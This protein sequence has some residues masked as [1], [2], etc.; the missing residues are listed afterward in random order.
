[1]RRFLS[2]IV[3]CSAVS[4]AAFAAPLTFVYKGAGCTGL[5]ALGQYE[6]LIGRKVDGVADF[7]DFS[8]WQNMLI[9]ANWGLNCWSG[10]VANISLS[11]PMAVSQNDGAPLQ[12]LAAGD[13]NSYYTQLAKMLVSYGFPNAFLR[14]GEEFNGDWY[15]WAAANSPTIWAKGFQQIVTTM[16]AV[17]GAKFKFVW[18]PALYAQKVSPDLAYP[19]DGYVDVVGT[20]AYDVS[21][22][23]GYTAPA[24]RWAS[25]YGDSWG[26]KEVLAFAKSHGKPVSFPEWGTGTQTDGHAGG[27][28]P[29]YVANMAAVI[30]ASASNIAYHSY[31]DSNDNFNGQLSG[32]PFPAAMAAFMTAL[33]SASAGSTSGVAVE[34][35]TGAILKAHASAF[36]GATPLSVTAT[37]GNATAIQNGPNHHEIMVWSTGDV[38]ATVTLSWGAAASAKVFNPATGATPIQTLSS[39][40]GATLRLAV[41]QPMII[42]IAK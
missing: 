20:D 27:D 2:V 32:G 41:G 6:T 9:G 7:I 25:I 28:D 4:S 8:T 5:A 36:N 29:L 30:Q 34:H 38:A 39:A 3:A 19:G 14:I 1:M 24:T 17:P 11:V 35:N 26:V 23:L 16:R 18:N 15:P 31:W 12:E 40:T 21:Y 13:F 10:K 33:G 37:G 42:S 22:D